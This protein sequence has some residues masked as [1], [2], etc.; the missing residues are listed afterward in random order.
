VTKP[1]TEDERRRPPRGPA[2][3]RYHDRPGC[4]QSSPANIR[5]DIIERT[6]GIPL[7]VEEMTK[8]ALEAEG[9][10]EARRTAARVRLRP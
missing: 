9:E 8:A 6:D 2:R 3:E 10:G 1:V 4:R 5:Q 7:F